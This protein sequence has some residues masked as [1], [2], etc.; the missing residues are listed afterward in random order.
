MKPYL[1]IALIA[2]VAGFGAMSLAGCNTIPDCEYS[3]TTAGDIDI[4][5]KPI[6]SPSPGPVQ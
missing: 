5:C 6:S 1:I 2:F 3:G 4:R